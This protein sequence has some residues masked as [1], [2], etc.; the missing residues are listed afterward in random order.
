MTTPS[1]QAVRARH[2][3]EAMERLK[4]QF[5]PM[6]VARIML[7]MGFCRPEYMEAGR[8]AVEEAVMTYQM[9]KG[10]FT[11]HL[12][13]VLSRRLIDLRRK[14]KVDRVVPI[15]SL[16]EEQREHIVSG[17]SVAAYQEEMDIQRRREEIGRFRAELALAGLTLQEVATSA[18]K[19]AE[20]RKACRRACRYM[21]LNRDL[22]EKARS[23]RVPVR[24]LS[25][26]LEVSPKT[27]E[28]HRKYL[29]ACAIAVAGEYH[30]ISGYILSREGES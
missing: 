21:M 8:L 11:T 12:R 13:Q 18:P 9:E 20:T 15:S 14:E 3:P 28:R 25:D 19:H 16:S 27:W 6:I 2:D 4:H 26:A 5:Q 1:Q 7:H 29:V 22:L 23:G 17:A 24:E 30:C 10:G